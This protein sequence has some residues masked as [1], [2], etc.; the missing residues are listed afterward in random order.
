M[1][2]NNFYLTEEK[3]NIFLREV[4]VAKTVN[5]KK[6]FTIGDLIWFNIVNITGEKKLIIMMN[7]DF[8]VMHYYVLYNK[9]YYA[10][11]ATGRV[12]RNT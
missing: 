4:K 9:L 10:H 2:K 11:I 7:D 1:D 6:Q 5:V 12:G 8:E 3:Y